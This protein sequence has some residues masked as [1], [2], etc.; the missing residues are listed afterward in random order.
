MG[1]RPTMNLIGCGRL[2]R[3]LGYL[4]HRR[5]VFDLGGILTRS[6]ESAREAAAVMGAGTAVHS[7][8]ALP[9]ADLYLIATPDDQVGACC[10]RLA[11]RGGLRPG[12]VVFHCSGSLSSAE[13]RAAAARGALTASIHP[14]KSFA[15]VATSARTFRNT[16]CGLEGHDEACKVLAR[17]FG[18]LGART[19][20]LSTGQK[21]LY[22]AGTVLAS[23]YLVA[24]MEVGF[25][26]LERAGVPR[27]EA[28]RF[29]E[30]LATETL[31]NVFSIGVVGALT[32]PISRGDSGTVERHL[33]ALKAWDPAVAELYSRLGAIALQ[34]AKLRGLGPRAAKALRQRLRQAAEFLNE[35]Q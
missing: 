8:K 22:H 33:A 12:A 19:F 34:V 13:L 31:G 18:R 11:A 3:T 6:P 27:E 16:F 17:A 10:R 25:R 15:D 29:I 5:K 2:G 4:F 23:N 30:P 24:L 9:Q 35:R 21:A 20:R 1:A 14:V 26:C 7:Y 32:G 28:R